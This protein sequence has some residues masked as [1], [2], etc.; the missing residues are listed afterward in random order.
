V[1]GVVRTIED[2]VVAYV[3]RNNLRES[4]REFLTE[5]LRRLPGRP[6]VSGVVVNAHSQG[7]ASFDVL[8]VCP[9]ESLGKVRAFVTAGSPLRKYLDLFSWGNDAGSIQGIEWLNFWDENYPVADPL[10]PPATWHFGD[11]AGGTPGE[12]GP[13]HAP[14]GLFGRWPRASRSW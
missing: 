1:L 6:D 9:Q 12:Q 10:S 4:I 2:D 8:R 7:V 14:V 11:I 5:A 3:C 13:F